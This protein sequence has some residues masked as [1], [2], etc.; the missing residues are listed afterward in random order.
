MVLEKETLRRGAPDTCSDCGVVI[1]LKVHHS[2][3]GYYIGAWC[4]CGPYCRESGYYPTREKA[5]TAFKTDWYD[6]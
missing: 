1:V 6:R 5:E 3:A 4:N 2:T